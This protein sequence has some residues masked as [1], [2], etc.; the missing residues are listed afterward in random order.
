MKTIGGDKINQLRH[1]RFFGDAD[2]VRA[3]MA[4]HAEILRPKFAAVQA[5][6]EERLA[7]TG[8]ASWTRP[9][10]G[11]F[12]SLDTAPGKAS[13]VCEMAARAGVK[14]TPAGATF[15]YGKDEADRNIRIAPTL[16]PMDELERALT[17]LTTAILAA[18]D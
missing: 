2:G 18:A 6:L 1:V 17:I 15:P 7:G 4:R 11:Y 10:G 13:Q 14:L 16:P 8:L 9:R 5:G 3:H 12:V